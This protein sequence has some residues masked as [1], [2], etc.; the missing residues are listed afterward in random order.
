M[1][2]G[3]LGRVLLLL[4]AAG[5]CAHG[6]AQTARIAQND[7]SIS[8]TGTWYS[9]TSAGGGTAALTNAKGAQAVLTFNGT[10]ITWIGV[11]DPYSGIAW[12]YLDGTFNSVDTY[13]AATVYQKPL[14]TAQGLAPGPHALSIEV[15]HMRDGS[16]SGSWVWIQEFDIQNGSSVTGGIVAGAGVAQESSPALIFNGQWFSKSASQFSGGTVLLA[17]DPGCRVSIN[18]TGTGITWIGYR[19]EWS[20]IAQ[21]YLDNTLTATVD[22]YLTPAQAQAS[23]YSITG[24][25]SGTHTLTITVTGT[26]S[27]ASQDSWVWV[28][29][30]NVVGGAAASPPTV[31]AGGVVNAGSFNPAPNN[32]VAQGQIISIFGSSFLASGRADAGSLPLP[33][34]LGSGNTSVNVCGQNIPLYNVFPGQINAQLPFECPASGT[35]QLTVTSAGQTSA[36]QTINLAA[37]SPGVFTV[38]SSGTG[39]GVILHGDNSLVSAAKPAKGGEQVVIY[40]TGLGRTAPSFPT[41]T[42]VTA[43]NA[44]VSPVTATIGGKNATVAYAGLTAGLVGL[45]QVNVVIPA[46]LSGSQPLVIAVGAGSSSRT[47]VTLSV[48]P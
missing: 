30:F 31:N 23:T 22:T 16:T 35:A 44:T 19:D 34:L 1:R 12:V 10:G 46:G 13:S 24:L 48:T 21:I 14:F 37:A 7:P 11:S 43:A 20:G 42:A 29:A 45:Y 39:D 47:G 27:A 38:N 28:D 25:S 9:N 36:A 26:H 41:G 2:E 40:C 17:T 32:Q 8:Y 3:H 5:I 33:T 18:F 15:P 4:A 6:V